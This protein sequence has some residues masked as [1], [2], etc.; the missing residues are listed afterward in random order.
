MMLLDCSPHR[1]EL[2]ERLDTVRKILQVAHS[3]A[4]SASS[5]ERE[6]RGM[7]IVLVYAAYENL[8]KTLCRSILETARLLR[9][10]NRRL[11]PGLQ[12]F[13]T[14]D[15]LQAVSDGSPSKIWK[16]TGSAVVDIFGRTRECTIHPGLFPNDGTNMKQSQV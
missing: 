1:T 8:L 4:S 6:S 12:L 3:S 5:I 15:A 13:A 16:S 2:Q 7:A 11:K 10:G 9:V 14:F